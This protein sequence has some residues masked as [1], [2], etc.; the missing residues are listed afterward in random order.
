MELTPR[1]AAFVASEMKRVE[2]TEERWPS[3]QNQAAEIRQQAEANLTEQ[4]QQK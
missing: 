3:A 1:Q 2:Q 4:P